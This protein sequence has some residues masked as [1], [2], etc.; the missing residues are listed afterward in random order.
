MSGKN[1]CCAGIIILAT[2]WM[3]NLLESKTRPSSPQILA[4]R[5]QK[6]Q[7]PVYSN[8][9]LQKS[10]FPKVKSSYTTKV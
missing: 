4:S 10:N 3:V 8:F 2:T 1:N 9:R 7:L 5:L 6:S